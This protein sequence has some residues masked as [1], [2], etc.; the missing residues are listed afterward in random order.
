MGGGISSQTQEA[1]VMGFAAIKQMYPY[2][3]TNQRVAGGS[4][5]IKGTRITVRTVAGYYQMGMSVDEILGALQHLTPAQVHSALAY[6]FDHQADID[7]DIK[8][9]ANIERWREEAFTHPKST[10]TGK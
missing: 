3:T 9:H 5:T 8:E 2:I 4:P 1:N 6:Y 7:Q 10:G